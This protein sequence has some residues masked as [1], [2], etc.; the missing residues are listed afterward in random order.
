MKRFLPL[1]CLLSLQVTAISIWAEV[2]LQSPP[3][4]LLHPEGVLATSQQRANESDHQ[5]FA[6]PSLI[7]GSTAVSFSDPQI[8]IEKITPRAHFVSALWKVGAD[9]LPHQRNVLIVGSD[10]A[11]IVDYLYGEGEFIVKRL[12]NLPF[13]PASPQPSIDS[14]GAGCLFS[15]SDGDK[16]FRFQ[17]LTPATITL[18]PDSLGKGV[19]FS[20]QSKLPVP[21]TTIMLAGK[22]EKLLKVDYVKAVNPMVVKLRVTFPDG[23]T[24]EIATAW[25]ARSLHIGKSEFDGWVAV[26]RHDPQGPGN[27]A[28][29]SSIEIR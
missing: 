4:L 2:S 14:E 29:E 10:Y 22:G 11:I 3:C 12:I 25:E 20:A 26:V 28:S 27:P 13:G 16:S 18:T 17:S 15:T 1:V 7:V 21:V 24:D 5:E 9:T 19:T 8:L 6:F 23:R